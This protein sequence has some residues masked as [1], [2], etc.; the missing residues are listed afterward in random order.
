[1]KTEM[2]KNQQISEDISEKISSVFQN[3]AVAPVNQNVTD[4]IRSLEDKLLGEQDDR[5]SLKDIIINETEK[6]EGKI[7]VLNRKNES[8]KT[9]LEDYFE[10]TEYA[11][12][13][14]DSKLSENNKKIVETQV[15]VNNN[16]D[17]LKTGLTEQAEKLFDDAKKQNEELCEKAYDNVKTEVDSLN[18]AISGCGKEINDNINLKSNGLSEKLD[19]VFKSSDL[20]N[21]ENFKNLLT[22]QENAQKVYSEA[23]NDLQTEL[24][25]KLSENHREALGKL[26]SE[27]AELSGVINELKASLEAENVK[28]R[29]E[30]ESGLKIVEQNLTAEAENTLNTLKKLIYGLIGADCVLLAGLIAAIV[31]V[32]VK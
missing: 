21:Q 30:T 10:D 11:I 6:I 7:D 24:K 23:V 19:A 17:S 12:D 8:I 22:Q 27:T 31:L 9:Q 15:S 5:T 26:A 4:S 32:I 18:K 16:I 14:L 29:R 28:N 25:N 2:N 3:F 13:S 20:Q 1:M